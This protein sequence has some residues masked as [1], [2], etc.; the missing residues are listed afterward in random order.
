MNDTPYAAKVMP[1]LPL[2]I[3]T[4]AA[5]V[6]RDDAE[7]AAQEALMRAWKAWP[8][9][10]DDA[11]VRPWLVRIVINVCFDWQ[12]GRFGTSRRRNDILP[13]E[14]VMPL[15]LLGSDPGSSDHATALDLR[16][17]VNA[18]TYDL[19]QSVILRYYV[20]LDASEIGDAMRIPAA[21]VRTRL[22]RALTL[23]RDRLNLSI[24]DA[25]EVADV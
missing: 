19:R 24:P 12:R 10:G 2:L 25:K 11:M 14:E 20:G 22:R 7:D 15:T 23:L 17:A 16:D 21:T 8:T 5:L 18:L 3:R 13:D 9:L 4:A 6:G 1:Y